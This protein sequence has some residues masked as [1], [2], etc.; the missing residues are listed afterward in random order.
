MQYRLDFAIIY[1]RWTIRVWT[2]V[3]F[4]ESKFCL[5]FTD[6]RQLVWGIPKERFDEFNVAERDC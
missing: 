6:R 1:V 3:L 5:N 4:T 2:P